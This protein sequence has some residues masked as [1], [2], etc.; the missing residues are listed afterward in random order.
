VAYRNR[1]DLSFEDVSVAWGFDT[2][3][4]S[5]GMC[6][7]DLDGDGDLDVVVNNLNGPAGIYRNE[8]SA[9]RVAVRLKGLPP[10]TRGI[11]GKIWVYGGAVPMQSQEM[12]CGGR[13]LS[14]DDPMRVFAAGS[15]TNQMRIEVR[16]RR[17]KRSVVNGVRA[18][19]IYEVD[20]AAAEGSNHQLSTIDHQPV[21]EDVSQLLQHSHHEEPY[22]DFGRQPLLPKK[23]SQ[24]GPGVAWYDVDGDGWEDLLVG[25][26]RGGRLA[27]YLNDAK[28]GFKLWNSVPF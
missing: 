12:I 17:G 27:V 23:L 19:R 2:P 9:P 20:E 1:G 5:H 26:G 10:N 13:Y 7:A 22:D 25:S 24:L 6:L 14:S 16:W 28:G 21:Y 8:S 3:G 18:N 4:V 11:G 15:L